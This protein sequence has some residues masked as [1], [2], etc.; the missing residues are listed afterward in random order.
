MS[1]HRLIVA[2]A[3]A[4]G[5]VAACSSLYVHYRLLT[6]P[7]FTSFCDVNT[8]VSCA[9][10]YLSRYG[11]LFGVPVALFGALYFAVVLAIASVAWK[12][13]PGDPAPAYI[14]VLSVPALVFVVYLA[15]ASFFVLNALCILC[16]I[17]YV[18]VGVI[19]IASRQAATVSLSSL[20]ARAGGDVRRLVSSPIAIVVALILLTAGIAAAKAFPPEIRSAA[21]AP[22]IADL[23]PVTDAERAKLAEWWELQP[24]VDVPVDG[25]GAKVV[26]VKFNDYQCPACGL[27]YTSYKT[28]L[29]R[30]RTDV[31]FVTK[32]YPLE[33]ECNAGVPTGNH[34]GS[35]EAAAAVNLA[36]KQGTAEK[37]E[38]WLFDNIGPPP[39][40]SAQVREAARTVGGIAD[41]EAQY[42]EAVKEVRADADLG[43]RLKVASTPTFFING[44]RV[45]EILQPQYFNALIEIE[46]KK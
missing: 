7:S 5:L 46:L 21:A 18:A 15:Y 9:E 14:L 39:L 3:A 20:P 8:T 16:A 13:G 26:V 28:V 6:D 10:A 27:T 25:G 40:S 1:S 4:A 12:M 33:P 34:Y 44:R 30:N 11:H 24:K 17:T 35:C 43:N 36:R 42:P 2:I 41:F 23:P 45:P 19:A 31:T 38:D 22:T 29:A 37:L 32:H